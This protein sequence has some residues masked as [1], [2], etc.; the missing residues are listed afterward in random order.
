MRHPEF[1]ELTCLKDLTLNVVA[2]DRQSLL[3]LTKLI[4]RSPFLH[5][6]TLEVNLFSVYLTI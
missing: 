5:R 3:N 1:P 6:F 2:S 4:E